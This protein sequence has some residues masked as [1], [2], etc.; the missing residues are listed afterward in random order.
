MMFDKWNKTNLIDSRYIWLPIVFEGE[1]L[2]IPWMEAW[3][4]DNMDFR[5][6][7]ENRKQDLIFYILDWESV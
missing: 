6:V 3:N 4:L 5:F 2:T 1:N 7:G